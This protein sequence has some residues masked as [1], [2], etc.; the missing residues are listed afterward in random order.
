MTSVSFSHPLHFSAKAQ[1]MAAG[2]SVISVNSRL[3]GYFV[4]LR[5]SSAVRTAPPSCG[6]QGLG[7]P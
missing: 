1:K 2:P 3:G 5:K 4:V 7:S 6:C